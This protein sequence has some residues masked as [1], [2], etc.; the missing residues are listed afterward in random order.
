MC[1]GYDKT[2]MGIP[3]VL[4]LNVAK[5]P[6]ALEYVLWEVPWMKKLYKVERAH[7]GAARMVYTGRDRLPGRPSSSTLTWSN[8]SVF[9]HIGIEATTES[10]A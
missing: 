10:S 1:E 5:I 4:D 3:D 6:R 8:E 7:E 2:S 9:D